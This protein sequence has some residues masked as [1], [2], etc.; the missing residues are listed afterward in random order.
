MLDAVWQRLGIA[1]IIRRQA[2]K[3]RFDLERA[4]FAM[5]ANR[6]CAPVS[7]LYCHEQWLKEDALAA[8]RRWKPGSQGGRRR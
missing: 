6:A 2:G 4:L 5:L 1:D 8:P 7:K 3:L